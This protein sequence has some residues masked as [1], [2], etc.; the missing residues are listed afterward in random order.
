MQVSQGDYIVLEVS[1]RSVLARCSSAPAVGKK[2]PYKANVCKER[3]TEKKTV[4]AIDFSLNEVKANLGR[5][6]PIGAVYGQKVEPLLKTRTSKFWEEIRF[7]RHYDE[8]DESTTIKEISIAFKKLRELRLDG[9]SI[10]LEIRQEHGKF[11]GWYKFMPKKD[12]D[13]MCV[14][15]PKNNEDLHYI[16]WHEY[17]HGIWYRRMTSRQRLAWVQL[18]HT[19]VV[20]Q[21]VKASDLEDIREE[22]EKAGSISDFLRE[23]DE[24]TTTIFKTIMR[25][26]TLIHGLTKKHLDLALTNGESIADYWP[27]SLEISEKEVSITDYA[28]K[29]PEELFA[30]SFAHHIAGRKLPKKIR[31]LLETTLAKLTR[32]IGAQV[33]T[34]RDRDDDEP[35]ETKSK[36]K[37]RKKGLK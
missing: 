3:D 17:G 11:A 23:A 27:A 15:P 26:I 33:A 37:K 8:A 34:K 6:P 24:Q 10:E 31:L 14:K 30:E 16:V 4:V 19:Y 18:Y 28:R 21:E 5:T 7:Y 2:G 36:K 13:V 22:V 35:S 32:A 25:Q 1:K 20:P 29:S 9:V 12:A